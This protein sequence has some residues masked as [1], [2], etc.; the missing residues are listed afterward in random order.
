MTTMT[1]NEIIPRDPS[2]L[3]EVKTGLFPPNPNMELW[4][5]QSCGK[6]PG[7]HT[8]PL[9]PVWFLLPCELSV[10]PSN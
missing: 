9:A 7:D 8:D 2:S 10:L 4:K 5:P 6:T 3:F 1:T